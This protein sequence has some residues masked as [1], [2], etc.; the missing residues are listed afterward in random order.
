M[1]SDIG[2]RGSVRPGLYEVLFPS[3]AH[4][5]EIV[6]STIE[7]AVQAGAAVAASL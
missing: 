6:D 2:E 7:A 4:T 1:G 3:L 5:D